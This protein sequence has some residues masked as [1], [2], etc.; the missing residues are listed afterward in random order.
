VIIKDTHCFITSEYP[1]TTSS[2][3]RSLNSGAFGCPITRLC[4][5]NNSVFWFGVTGP[6]SGDLEIDGS[7]YRVAI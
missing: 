1:A 7:E 6:G 4:A 5:D 3:T 2:V